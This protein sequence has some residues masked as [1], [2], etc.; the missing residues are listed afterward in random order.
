MS[1]NQDNELEMR[2]D[3]EL[4]SLPL[5]AAPPTLAP[6]VMAA[7]TSRASVPW[8]RQP[9]EAW[10][11]AVRGAALVVLAVFFTSLCLG[12][13]RLPDTEGYLAASRHA[14]GWFSFVTTLWN[15]LNAVLG[16]LALAAQ[17]LNR[18]ILV[19]CL[20]AVTLAWAVCLGLG[21]AC[22]RFALARR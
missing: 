10:P 13:W 9:W 14:T 6:R 12:V 18:V 19:G 11:A 17:Q 5:L 2:I 8:Y 16:T 20:A 7:I 22:L 1:A 4:K 21:T 3:R 15:A